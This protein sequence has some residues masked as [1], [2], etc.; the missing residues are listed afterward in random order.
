MRPLEGTT[1]RFS[2]RE[3]ESR[4]GYRRWEVLIDGEPA[5]QKASAGDFTDYDQT[6]GLYRGWSS[7][8]TQAILSYNTEAGRCWNGV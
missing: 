3:L 1:N 7:H 5:G 4:P 6:S 2:T 8:S